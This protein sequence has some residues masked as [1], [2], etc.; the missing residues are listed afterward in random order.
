[1]MRIIITGANSYI[2]TSFENYMKQF[3]NQYQIDTLDM[4]DSSW[5][6]VSFEGYDSIFHVAGIAH[7]KETEE[8]AHLYY[9]VNRDLP[10][11]VA[12]KAKAEGVKQF[13]FL[14]SMSVYGLNTG[15]ITKD[16]VPSPKSNYGK[17]KLQAENELMKLESDAFKVAILRPPMVY[18]KGCKGN[19][20]TL[21]KLA[22]KLPVFPD[23]KNQRSMIYITNLSKFVHCLIDHNSS[24]IFCPQN[25]EYTDTGRMVLSIAA[26]HGGKIR[27]TGL[28]NPAL[29]LL[30]PFTGL[31]DK[32]FGSLVYEQDTGDYP[33]E[34][35]QLI[36]LLDSIDETEK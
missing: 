7:I 26:A 9:E 15:I 5:R 29:S 21:R 19:Y 35:Y 22:L 33:D 20:Q 24:G 3:G 23:V 25:T 6:S 27:L 36:S 28:F 8:N 13:V 2:G 30:R 31:V 12:E 4:R 17:S 18:G 10:I 32:A 11:E 14:S 34:K 16:T 1:M